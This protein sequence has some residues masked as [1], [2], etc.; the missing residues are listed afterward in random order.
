MC[1]ISAVIS[2]DF[3]ERSSSCGGV[4]GGLPGRLLAQAT[5]SAEPRR[6]R[7]LPR[8]WEI[9]PGHWPAEEAF[10]PVLHLVRWRQGSCRNWI[11]RINQPAGFG[12]TLA[13]H[14]GCRHISSW[15]VVSARVG[16]LYVN[17]N[18]IGA[19]VGRQPFGGEAGVPAPGRRPAARI[20]CSGWRWNGWSASTRLR[21]VV[22]RSCT[23]K[24][25]SE[26]R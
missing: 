16:N 23:A 7:M 9:E 22:R 6:G 17:R 1:V 13:L 26:T 12:L 25:G 10:G 11:E 24:T 14:C 2:A 4:P 15:L 18:Q 21:W 3:A 5:L 8:R 19:V 20:I